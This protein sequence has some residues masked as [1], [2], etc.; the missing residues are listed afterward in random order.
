M[1]GIG[2]KNI[3]VTVTM[4]RSTTLTLC[5]PSNKT[6]NL[7][8]QITYWWENIFKSSY[9]GVMPKFVKKNQGTSNI[10]INDKIV[11]NYNDSLA[12]IKAYIPP[13]RQNI[14]RRLLLR[15]LT[16]KI[17]LLRHLTQGYQHVGIF[18]VRWRQFLAS[19]M[20]ISFFLCIFHSR[21]LTNANP[22]FSGI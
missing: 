8:S 5:F 18:C 19:A 1:M 20:Y 10:L 3:N 7:I 17:V 14:W 4:N 11:N 16:Q 12:W 21:Q 2:G 13:E 15:Y 9:P 22:I 6:N